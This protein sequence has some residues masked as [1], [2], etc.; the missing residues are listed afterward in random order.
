MIIDTRAN[1][2]AKKKIAKNSQKVLELSPEEKVQKIEIS[3]I[4]GNKQKRLDIEDRSFQDTTRVWCGSGHLL[5]CSS[6][7]AFSRSA[8]LLALFSL[9]I[10]PW[11]SSSQLS[12]SQAGNCLD[13][14]R[15]RNSTFLS[16]RDDPC[17]MQT[18]VVSFSYFHDQ[19]VSSR[20]K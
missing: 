6:L 5:F 18:K 7:Q 14:A 11:P 16:L 13:E 4:E 20:A 19:E 10:E 2:T 17:C 9:S 8:A 3:Q 12:L 15:C 1:C